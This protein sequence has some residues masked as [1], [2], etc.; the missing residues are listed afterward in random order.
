MA[1]I[2]LDM[3]HIT[4]AD[5][6]EVTLAGSNLKEYSAKSEIQSS[7]VTIDNLGAD[8]A[9]K[10]HYLE[11]SLYNKKKTLTE[12][13]YIYTT[14]PKEEN[15]FTLRQLSGAWSLSRPQAFNA[16]SGDPRDYDGIVFQPAQSP[17]LGKTH[18]FY[19]FNHG[20]RKATGKA[21]ISHIISDESIILH[22]SSSIPTETGSILCANLEGYEPSPWKERAFSTLEELN[23]ILHKPCSFDEKG[24]F[25]FLLCEFS[26]LKSLTALPLEHKSELVP[27]ETVKLF[28][29]AQRVK[30]RIVS[31]P[32]ESPM[33]VKDYSGIYYLRECIQSYK[34]FPVAMSETVVAHHNVADLYIYPI[35]CTNGRPLETA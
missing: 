20:T 8:A 17:A 15:L 1:E 30:T 11:I 10:P 13:L 27:E 35:A 9:K 21:Y 34:V 3:E 18:F 24:S 31:R 25:H 5:T 26:K 14:L 32:G 22:A 29:Q 33:A 28:P 7:R 4:D 16:L 12:R 2:I 19:L 6:I 23:P